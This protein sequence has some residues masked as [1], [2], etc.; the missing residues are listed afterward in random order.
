[1]KR[2]SFFKFL[3]ALVAAPAAAAKCLGN[4]VVFPIRKLRY[5]WHIQSAAE[6]REIYGSPDIQN[7]LTEAMVKLLRAQI[8]TM[9]HQVM[10]RL[11]EGFIV[12]EHDPVKVNV[13]V[14]EVDLSTVLPK[15]DIKLDRRRIVGNA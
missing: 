3:G 2:R 7:E 1:M 4:V 11:E 14:K 8:D 6:L 13:V 15:I 5:T 12:K 10:S 9:E